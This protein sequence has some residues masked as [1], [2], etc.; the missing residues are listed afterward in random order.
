VY[1]VSMKAG[2]SREKGGFGHGFVE[3]ECG[4]DIGKT[5]TG[6]EYGNLRKDV[7][8]WRDEHARK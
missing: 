3:L 2:D 6:Y 1:V 4:V 7:A 5:S 8:M